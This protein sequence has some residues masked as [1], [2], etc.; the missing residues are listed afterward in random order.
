MY[1]VSDFKV[2]QTAYIENLVKTRRGR[3]FEECFF[4]CDVEK[5]GRKYVTA[6]RKQFEESECFK[7][8]LAEHSY[9]SPE[10]V[11]WPSLEAITEKIEKE[12]LYNTIKTAFSIRAI[13]FL[14]K[15]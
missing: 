1:K 15:I 3:P 9:Y 10:Y 14:W 11:L 6:D 12:N 2:G 13:N 5:V 4:A 8:G 7:G